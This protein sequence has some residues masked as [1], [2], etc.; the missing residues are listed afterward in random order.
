[1]QVWAVN[2]DDTGLKLKYGKDATLPVYGNT[3]S[4]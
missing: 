3:A 1:M 4:L 2:D